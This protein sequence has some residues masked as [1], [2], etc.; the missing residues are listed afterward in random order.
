MIRAQVTAEVSGASES[1]GRKHSLRLAHNSELKNG[2]F[3]CKEK[4]EFL[5]D[6]VKSIELSI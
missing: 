3:N 2:C 4:R 1:Q 6:Q 5:E